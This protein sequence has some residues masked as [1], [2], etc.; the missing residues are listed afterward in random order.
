MGNTKMAERAG[1]IQT[2]NNNVG[3]ASVPNNGTDTHEKE[4]FAGLTID[5]DAPITK[6]QV[7]AQ[8]ARKG[9][10]VAGVLTER[11]S[12][13]LTQAIATFTADEVAPD[14]SYNF[15]F[16][17]LNKDFKSVKNQMQD[18][19]SAAGLEG[20]VVTTA[21]HAQSPNTATTKKEDAEK[22]LIYIASVAFAETETEATD[23]SNSDETGDDND[24][25]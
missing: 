15:V 1:A 2:V 17:C 6:A 11:D 18:A 7:K 8:A 3:G 13:H 14:A 21:K 4:M 24:G 9:R 22:P 19:I 16:W 25:E 23:D 5:W 10:A 20:V 12:K